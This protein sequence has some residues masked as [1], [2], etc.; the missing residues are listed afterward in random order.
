MKR[1][2]TPEFVIKT[3][4][5]QVKSTMQSI[6]ELESENKKLR[7]DLARYRYALDGIIEAD[8]TRGYPTGKEWLALIHNVKIALENK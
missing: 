4:K 2:H 6:R 7:S 5:Q 3:L 8:R 1:T